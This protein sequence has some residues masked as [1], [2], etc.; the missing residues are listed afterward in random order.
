MRPLFIGEAP[1]RSTSR[2]G[3]APLVG[4]S[5]HRLAAWAGLSPAEF[6]RRAEL[7]NLFAALPERW[8]RDAARGSAAAL[9]A[10][11]LQP[12]QQRPVVLLGEKV[13]LAFAAS[14]CVLFR[15]YVAAT[16]SL[17][18]MPHPSGLN[19]YWND[20]ANVR[21]AERFLRKLMGVTERRPRQ[22]RL[23]LKGATR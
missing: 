6:R 2:A 14:G 12:D 23:A 1:S 19:H 17:T 9:A 13:A 3:A 10:Q 4:E 16:G 21:R 15:T 7:I 8:D 22:A 20:A 11:W 5:G 18:V